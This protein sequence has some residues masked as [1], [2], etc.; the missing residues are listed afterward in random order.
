MPRIVRMNISEE[1]ESKIG[2][3][4]KIGIVGTGYAAQKRAEALQEDDRAELIAVTG[5]KPEKITS[6]SQ[7][8]AVVP[9]NSWQQLIDRPDLDLI[10]ICNINSEHGALA[11]AALKAGKHVVVEYP[12]ALDPKEA[13]NLIELSQKK[14]KLLHVEH[15]ELI[16]GVHQSIRQ[17]LPIL[18]NISYVRYA[19]ISPQRPVSDRWNYNHQMFGF[20]FTAALSRIHRLTDLFGTVATVTCQTRFWDSP[21]KGYFTSCLSQAQLRF[22]NGILADV[23]YG[24]GEALSHGYRNFEVHGDEGSL[25]FEGERGTLIKGREKTAIAIASKKGSFARDTKMVLD[26]LLENKPLYVNPWASCY[27]LE[28]ADA[29][30]RSSLSETTVAIN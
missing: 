14:Q 4:V 13:K 12:L 1:T 26:N 2:Q 20:P 23:T 10:F 15:I 29:A 6:F 8:F 28:V 9:L 18:G 7:K 3:F 22:T 19:T 5:N 11:L 25:M 17:H 16:G 24:K 27:A 21:V 30:R